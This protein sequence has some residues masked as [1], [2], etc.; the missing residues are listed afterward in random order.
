MNTLALCLPDAPCAQ[1][2]EQYGSA[3]VYSARV[4]DALVTY[5]RHW[6]EVFEDDGR[7]A[8]LGVLRFVYRQ[9]C[10]MPPAYPHHARQEW[11]KKL[12]AALVVRTLTVISHVDVHQIGGSGSGQRA[13][14][15]FKTT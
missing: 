4:N 6:C 14:R 8:S 12:P 7:W 1:G 10:T 13:A 9:M 3:A 11:L 5:A 2:S 15:T